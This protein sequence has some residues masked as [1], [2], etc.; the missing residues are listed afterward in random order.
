[1]TVGYADTL[2]DLFTGTLG[3]LVA[4]GFVLL[5]ARRHGSTLSS[6]GSS[7]AA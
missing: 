7:R 5:W 6:T 3:S 2:L 1:M 4:G